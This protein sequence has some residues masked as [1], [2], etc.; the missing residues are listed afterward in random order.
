MHST[1]SDGTLPVA[2]L[3][4]AVRDAGVG[5]FALTDHDTVDG[6]EETRDLAHDL[7]IETLTGIE[8]STHIDDIAV[9]MLGYG[10]EPTHPELQSMLQELGQARHGRIPAM[11]ERLRAL[12]VPVTTE[13]VMA[14]AAGGSPGRPHVAR[15]LVNAGHCATTQEAFNRFLGDGKPAHVKK[16]E[17]TAYQAI[18]VLR[19]AGGVAVWAHPLARPLHRTGG[20]ERLTR[21]LRRAGLGGLE[22]THPAHS[23]DQRRKLRRLCQTLGMLETGGSDFHGE[24]SPGVALGVGRGRDEVPLSIFEGLRQARH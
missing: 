7:G 16:R 20:V 9:H 5:A 19:S 3:V 17:P 2:Q 15:A 6:L 10:F 1:H 23:P 11:V 4:R 14:V 18:R 24:N 13:D 21:E 22:V 8:I 12:G